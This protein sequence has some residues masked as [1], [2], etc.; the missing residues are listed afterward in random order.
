MFAAICNGV[1]RPFFGWV[2]DQIGRIPT[3][4]IAFAVGAV[5]YVLFSVTAYAPWG[6]VV[7]AGL[8]MFSWGEIFDLFPSTCTDLFG[9]RYA[10]ANLSMLYTAKGVASFLVPLGTPAF[11]G[12]WNHV[13]Y[14]AAGINVI[15]VILVLAVLW[16]AA[17]R[18]LRETARY[19]LPHGSFARSP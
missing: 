19:E 11:F 2:S 18:H 12:S 15:A 5:A 16:P 10:T 13:L 6:F 9:E 3:M 14:A 1:A 8:I 7:F 17:N 4:A